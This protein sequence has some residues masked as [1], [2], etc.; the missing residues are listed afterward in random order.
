MQ[1][2]F[3]LDRTGFCYSKSYQFLVSFKGTFW[4]HIK[5]SKAIVNLRNLNQNFHMLPIWIILL[6]ICISMV[7]HSSFPQTE[8]RISFQTKMFL[9]TFN[10]RKLQYFFKFNQYFLNVKNEFKKYMYQHCFKILLVNISLMAC[11]GFPS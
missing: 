11:Q 6:V 10:L 3:F 1:V 5:P 9:I 7:A 8:D 2:N 4:N